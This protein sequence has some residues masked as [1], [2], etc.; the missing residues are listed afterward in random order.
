MCGRFTQLRP[1]ADLV[2]L[3][4]VTESAPSPD[5]PPRYNVAP[6]LDV[7]VLRLRQDGAR[8]LEPMRWGLV[9]YWSKNI[10]IGN[11]LINA[12]A[13][14]LAEKPAFR[15]ALQRRRCLIPADGFYEW[16]KQ[17]GRGRQPYRITWA[18][19]PP[20]AFA[21]LWE[22]WQSGPDA[23]FLLSCTIVTVEA[24]ERVRPLHDRMPAILDEAAQDVWLDVDGVDAQAACALLRPLDPAWTIVF[25]VDRYVNAAANEGPRCIAPPVAG[26]LL[27]GLDQLRGAG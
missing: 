12:R 4:R 11:R 20:L 19:E 6:T 9:P 8:L 21:G 13:E 18:G 16:A 7:P 14:T 23:P 17:P 1:W 25:P 26:D 22:R 15:P 5:W 27:A 2:R 24:N 10:A 3:Y